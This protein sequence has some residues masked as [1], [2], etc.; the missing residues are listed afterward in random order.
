MPLG[1]NREPEYRRRIREKA[2]K[3]KHESANERQEAAN[4][5]YV[6]KIVASID[7]MYEHYKRESHKDHT[8]RKWDR[9]WEIMG[10]FGL[11]LAAGVGATAVWIGTNDADLQRRVAQGQLD[12]MRG[13]FTAT[14]RPWISLDSKPEI[15]APLVIGDNGINT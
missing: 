10:V 5:A 9:F 4:R 6:N 8:R 11:W 13:E 15:I 12:V 3:D 1:T 2:D 7:A 14:N